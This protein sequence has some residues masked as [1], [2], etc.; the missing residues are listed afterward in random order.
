MF[1]GLT[2][3]KNTKLKKITAFHTQ[4]DELTTINVLKYFNLKIEDLNQSNHPVE[5]VEHF[6]IQLRVSKGGT[7]QLSKFW[8]QLSQFVKQF[9]MIARSIRNWK[10]YSH[11]HP[12][13]CN[14]WLLYIEHSYNRTV[15]SSS[16]GVRGGKCTTLHLPPKHQI[17]SFFGFS[18][19][20][21]NGCS[22]PPHSVKNT[23]TTM[24]LKDK[25]IG[26]YYVKQIKEAHW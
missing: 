17:K 26:P 5:L 18:S 14:E 13:N 12:E 15:H 23:M 16:P 10:I 22:S 9:E 6:T 2:T 25:L 20:S 8:F 4:T 24:I 11:K 3:Y 1:F 7:S 19:S 21:T